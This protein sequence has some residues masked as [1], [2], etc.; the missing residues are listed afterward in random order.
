MDLSGLDTPAGLVDVSRMHANL[1]RVGS[2]CREHGLSWRPHVKTHK[3]PELG[4]AQ[5]AAGARGLSV[6][7]PREAEVMAGITNDLLFAYPPVGRAKLD[8]L[9][10]LP[11]SLEL[12]V[13]LD[14]LEA[15]RA[16]GSRAAEEGREL[17]VLV[18]IDVGLH[19]VGVPTPDEAL[20][21]AREAGRLDGTIYRGV[22]LYPGHIRSSVEDQ[23]PALQGVSRYLEQVLDVLG[24]ADLTPEV[25]S[26]GST[27]TLFR[28]HEVAGLTEVR[29]GMCI[30]NDRAIAAIGACRWEDCAYTVLATVVSTA[31]PGQAV[32]DA[33]SKALARE[34]LRAPG[35]GY[36]VLLD[37]PAVTVKALSEEHGILDLSETD[38]RP[39]VG[40]RVRVI[41]N[42]VCASVNL[43]ERL[44][45]VSGG[46][47]GDVWEVAARGRKRFG[48]Q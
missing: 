28:S 22:M 35:G 41:P 37:R 43:Q 6:A 40:D 23:G 19:R 11:E 18:E 12:T 1:E 44:Y 29:A 26:G 45:G 38:W 34:E 4:A 10:A 8:R 47:V 48:I 46:E 15:L 42:H 9:V 31:C 21:L 24:S 7:T 27:P 13:G 14:S 36:G 3:T 17:G 20:G 2:Y 5:I 30:F 16:L 33:G 25:V 39:R 32:V